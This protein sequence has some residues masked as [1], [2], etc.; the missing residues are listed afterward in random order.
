MKFGKE[1]PQKCA[2]LDCSSEALWYPNIRIFAKGFKMAPPMS[3]L[4][5]L[6]VCEG[7][8]LTMKLE[9]VV[10]DATWGVFEKVIA[11]QGKAAPDRDRTQLSWWKIADAQAGIL[12]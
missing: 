7:C 2:S 9:D 3:T 10:T 6:P 12:P 5:S 1:G 8:S 11:A 4:M